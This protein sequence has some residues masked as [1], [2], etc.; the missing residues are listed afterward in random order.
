VALRTPLPRPVPNAVDRI[1]PYLPVANAATLP[2]PA[3][4]LVLDPN[5]GSIVLGMMS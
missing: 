4:I 5:P 2:Q 1:Y 3:E